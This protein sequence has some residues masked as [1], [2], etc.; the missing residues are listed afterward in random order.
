MLPKLR[1]RTLLIL[2]SSLL[3]VGLMNGCSKSPTVAEMIAQSRQYQ[4]KGQDSAAVIQL[5]NALQKQPGN[6][7]ARTLLGKLYFNMGNFAAAED[8]LRLVLQN[9]H[10]TDGHI[11]MM[12]G[13][14]YLERNEFQKLL[15][16]IQP[17]PVAPADQQAEMLVL[18]G[19][20]NLGTN[21]IP[22]AKSALDRA[23]QLAPHLFSSQLG[24]IRLL[25]AQGNLDSAEQ[26]INTI[27]TTFPNNPIGWIIKGDLDRERHPDAALGDYQK[28]LAVDPKNAQ[29]LASVISNYLTHSNVDQA[30]VYV[31]QYLHLYPNAI[32]G[33]YLQALIDFAKKSP[34]AASSNLDQA[35]KS[36][37]DFMPGVLLRGLVSAQLNH[38]EEALKDLSRYV[39]AFPASDYARVSLARIQLK[40]HQP[41]NALATL[42]PMLEGNHPSPEIAALTAQIYTESGHYDKAAQI[43]EQSTHQSPNN[44]V[45]LTQLA[46]TRLASGQDSHQAISELEQ[47]SNASPTY[48]NADSIL[49][50]TYLSKKNYAGALTETRRLIQRNPSIPDFY[51]LQGAAYLGL[52][53]VANARKSFHQAL[54]INPQYI[55]TQ[56]N[57]AELEILD[58]HFAEAKSGLD[59][60]LS[61][62]KNNL[63]AMQLLA[64]LATLQGNEAEHLDWLQKAAQANPAILS[65]HAELVRYLLSKNHP[66]QALDQAQAFVKANPSLPVAQELLGETQLG[67]GKVADAVG[68]FTKLSQLAP[69]D[70]GV[71]ERLGIVKNTN[72]D[73]PG[74]IA[75][76]KKALSLKPDAI[77]ALNRL[78]GLELSRNDVAGA[79]ALADNFQSHYP[80]SPEGDALKGDIHASQKLYEQALTDYA[81]AQ[82]LAKTSSVELKIAATLIQLGKTP[83]AQKHL[84]HWVSTY[85]QDLE[86]RQYLA[87]LDLSLHNDS[88]AMAQYEILQKSLPNSPDILN[89]LA[90][91]YFSAHHPL[92]LETAQ[93]AY[94]LSP[95]NVNIQDTLGWIE[96]HQGKLQDGLALLKQA[97]DKAPESG[98]IQYHYAVALNESGDHTGARSV[99]EKLLHANLSFPEKPNAETLL[100]TL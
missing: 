87:S 34:E 89:N 70:P 18:R 4:A 6:L 19:V 100:R 71:W 95:G 5:K 79:T 81:R 46:L 54:T 9:S 32:M 55:P 10:D 93:K 22:E 8:E 91:L 26:Q 68:T 44:P 40:A 66:D 57:L 27:T 74:A 28:A 78:V 84:A 12:L 65:P 47:A 25:I 67:T 7:E 15:D 82:S 16:E 23:Q 94:Q 76:L 3:S 2:T 92:A 83:E 62:D 38:D 52:H 59:Q 31:N 61:E 90:Y 88:A 56:L 73:I 69:N 43:L 41:D 14:I 39:S 75:A 51:N 58:K 48:L 49:A 60:V 45:L 85:P 42:Q 64:S 72:Q 24:Q 98:S 20:A 21:N 33:K 30:T 29:A 80:K 17:N 35:M 97:A 11:A 99:L 86:T 37:P 1:N 13:Q 53:D 36:A 96:I 77:P 63:T 50:I